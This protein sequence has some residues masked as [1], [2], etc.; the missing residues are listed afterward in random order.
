[1]DYIFFK[2]SIE[3]SAEQEGDGNGATG[4]E[5]GDAEAQTGVGKMLYSD[6][7]KAHE[8]NE[9]IR[10]LYVAAT[11]AKERLWLTA[12]ITTDKDGNISWGDLPMLKLLR[13]CP[14]V[15]DCQI[16]DVSE[17]LSPQLH[18]D[19]NVALKPI[20]RLPQGLAESKSAVQPVVASSATQS[21]DK[22]A[23]ATCKTAYGECFHYL[24]E[25]IAQDSEENERTIKP[26]AKPE[27]FAG[28]VQDALDEYSEMLQEVWKRESQS[29]ATQNAAGQSAAGQSAA[30]KG[31]TSSD[32]PSS[33]KDFL[34]QCRG[35][36]Y[37]HLANML[38]DA[39]GRAC[40]SQQISSSCEQGYFQNKSDGSLIDRRFDR[41]FIDSQGQHWVVDFKTGKRRPEKY[42]QQLEEYASMLS[43]TGA[44]DTVHL[45]LLYVAEKPLGQ[46]I[47]T[48]HRQ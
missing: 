2:V 26:G 25:R 27:E 30:G 6:M 48:W 13:E 36:L 29:A 16:E 32:L 41:Q 24:M 15:R 12:M 21:S 10:L 39:F 5:D 23:L 31:S 47:W 11:R 44:S 40:L 37:A 1:M 33:A 34:E 20:R 22:Y 38:N 42:H 14:L 35:K 8:Q 19:A 43:K 7:Q 4:Q 46:D 9:L 45:A 17:Q 3:N 28:L 18:E